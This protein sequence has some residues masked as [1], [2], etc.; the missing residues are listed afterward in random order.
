MENELGVD[1]AAEFWSVRSAIERD[2]PINDFLFR[3]AAFAY[4]DAQAAAGQNPDPFFNWIGSLA[5]PRPGTPLAAIGLWEWALG[6]AHDWERER[7]R[8]QH[9]GSGYYFAG[10]RDIA[11]GDIDRG[12]L[13]MHQAAIEDIYPDRDRIPESPAGYFITLDSS[14]A[15]QAY[16]DKVAEYESYLSES[17]TTWRRLDEG[18]LDSAELRSRLKT[19]KLLDAAAMLAHAVARLTRLNSSTVEQILDNRFAAQ[20]FAQIALELCLVIEDVLR[21]HGDPEGRL[22]GL[23]AQYPPGKDV[24]FTTDELGQLNRLAHE[25]FA[26]VLQELMRGITPPRFSRSMS[27]RETYL[28]VAMLVRNRAAHTLD[29]PD[30]VITEFADIIRC[31]FFGLFAAIEDVAS[32]SPLERGRQRTPHCNEPVTSAFGQ[33]GPPKHGQSERRN[34]RQRC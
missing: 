14:Q 32:S 25:D 15:N 12:M 10:V 13:Y 19:A 23:I 34:R 24:A 9:K 8:R 27:S 16:Y 2:Q 28:A 18:F 29:L 4:F 22:G 26:G 5:L 1:L 17:L 33:E 11:V 20:L 21:K 3:K 31:V 6:I 7:G 30:I